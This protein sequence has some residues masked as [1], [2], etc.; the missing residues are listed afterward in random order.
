MPRSKPDPLR[1]GIVGAGLLGSAHAEIVISSPHAVLKAV[2]ET[3]SAVGR[4]VVA[5][6]G[7]TWYPDC[8]RM[9]KSEELDA[10]IIATPDPLHKEPVIASARAGIP[11]ILTEK[12]LATTRSDALRMRDAILK[13]GSQ[14][15][16]LFP[17]RFS[18]LD[19]AVHYA[20]QKKL[21]GAPV[22][23]DV[24]LDDN[25]SVPT[26][27]WG[28]RS[29]EWAVGSSTAHFL[30]SHVVD[31]L[32]WYCRPAEIVEVRALTQQRVLKY[33]PDLYE[34]HLAF[35]N[36]LVV[37]TKSEWIRRMDALVEFEL[38]FSG[39]AGS[40]YYRKLPAFRAQAGLRIDLDSATSGSLSPHQKALAGR[41]IRGRIVSDP[42][43][44]TP[45]ALEVLPEDNDQNVDALG[46][47]L[48]TIRHGR[49]AP[50]IEGFGPLPGLDDALRQVEVV[51]AIVD[52]AEKNRTVKVRNRG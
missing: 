46:H 43:A 8:A 24:R 51:T 1:V 47:Y 36:G 30:F 3:R 32:R 41:G 37:R 38:G 35:D 12:P 39:K 26:N 22:Y 14:L 9:L 20:F 49:K 2:A 31:L 25:I 10:V 15:Y 44:R 27:L 29:R 5:G 21:I 11:Y 13:S 17:N 52:S 33:S 16:V 45:A 48:E 4:Q 6:T 23:G 28:K 19:R 50:R 40:L 42:K 34:A 18:P 7:A